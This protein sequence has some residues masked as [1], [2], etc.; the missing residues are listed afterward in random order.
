MKIKFGDFKKLIKEVQETLKDRDD[1]F[2]NMVQGLYREVDKFTN[3][4]LKDG[5]SH[6]EYQEYM[7]KLD[8]VMNGLRDIN[9]SKIKFLAK[10]GIS[11][12]KLA[13]PEYPSNPKPAPA[14]T[15][16]IPASKQSGVGPG[17]MSGG[18]I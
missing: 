7:N 6:E 2:D 14:T 10:S 13:E 16:D 11:K 8:T 18:R 9:V 15:Q 3:N 12:Q 5:I 4:L 17:P 1:G